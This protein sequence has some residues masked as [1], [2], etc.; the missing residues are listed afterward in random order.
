ME[1]YF[2]GLTGLEKVFLGCAVFGGGLF[3]LRMVLM[4]VGAD[5]SDVDMDVDVDMDIDMD[6]AD[7][8]DFDD[9]EIDEGSEVTF[10]GTASTGNGDIAT[11]TWT[12]EYDGETV[13]LEGPHP[14]SISTSRGC[15]PSPST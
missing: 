11:Y 6:A 14:P 8:T 4:L 12:F 3:I 5:Q 7:S 1:A 9:I 2:A 13:T 15:T 10:D